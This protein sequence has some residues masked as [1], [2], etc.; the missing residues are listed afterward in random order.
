MAAESSEGLAISPSEKSLT[1]SLVSE[2]N[3]K[4]VSG[5]PST[6]SIREDK[7]PDLVVSRPRKLDAWWLPRRKYIAG[8]VHVF[9]PL[10]ARIS[11]STSR[12]CQMR[13][14]QRHR[15]TR[16][17]ISAHM[18]ALVS[19]SRNAYLPANARSRDHQWQYYM[20]YIS[21]KPRDRLFTFVT[22]GY[23]A[24]L[25]LRLVVKQ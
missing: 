18:P 14:I 22:T 5:S 1:G 24:L 21:G 8:Y 17:R 2:E 13:V 4:S 10:S 9:D 23:Y 16:R 20:C 12:R 7:W 25:R 3:E 11:K 15:T 6:Y 19:L